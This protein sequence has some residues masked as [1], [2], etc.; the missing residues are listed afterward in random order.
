MRFNFSPFCRSNDSILRPVLGVVLDTDLGSVAD[1]AVGTLPCED[2]LPHVPHIH[3][4]PLAVEA[5]YLVEETVHIFDILTR[6][7]IK[8]L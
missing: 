7:S 4:P 8:G 2:I 6:L 5:H 3:L 1:T